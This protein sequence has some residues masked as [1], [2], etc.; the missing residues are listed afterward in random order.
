MI[1]TIDAQSVFNK[2]QYPFMVKKKTQQTRHRRKSLQH[3][4]GC[5]KKSTQL[6]GSNSEENKNTK[7]HS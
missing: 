7:M 2:I 5:G 4:K 1:T 6:L 3:N